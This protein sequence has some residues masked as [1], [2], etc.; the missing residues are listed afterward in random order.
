[1]ATLENI[2]N[3]NSLRNI[4]KSR[5]NKSPGVR[6]ALGLP[7]LRPNQQP[8]TSLLK[9]EIDLHQKSNKKD[10]QDAISAQ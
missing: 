4:K 6:K 8:L 10:Y 3:S 1:M 7:D 9:R 5:N 2:E